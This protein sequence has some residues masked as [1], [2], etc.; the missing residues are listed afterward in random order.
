MCS[1]V[2][3]KIWPRWFKSSRTSYDPECSSVLL[4][5]LRAT[6]RLQGVSILMKDPKC[7]EFKWHNP[8]S[9]RYSIS[10]E[11][12][13]SALFSSK[14]SLLPPC[15]KRQT[16]SGQEKF[17]RTR[18]PDGR[19][20]WAVHSHG[21]N[22]ILWVESAATGGSQAINTGLLLTALHFISW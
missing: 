5:F 2:N 17:Q 19:Q 11:Q 13:S 1:A 12:F 3:L 16:H 6:L 21:V 7:R 18:Q 9:P 14:L 22:T 20:E 10:S 8:R 4:D 15:Q